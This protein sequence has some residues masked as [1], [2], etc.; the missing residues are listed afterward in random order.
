MKRHSKI[1]V[2]GIKFLFLSLCFFAI[3]SSSCKYD[4]T[5]LRNNIQA[6]ENR[7]MTLEEWKTTLN[8][9]IESLQTIVTSLE[10][11]NFIT[12]VEPIYDSEGKEIGYKITFQTGDSID[13]KFGHDG[14][15]GKDEVTEKMALMVWMESHPLSVL[16]KMKTGPIIGL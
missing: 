2:I 16:F 4:D 5:E 3:K 13:I 10:T 1:M 14:K 7:V 9:S 12:K 8:K 11:K 6:L 15:D